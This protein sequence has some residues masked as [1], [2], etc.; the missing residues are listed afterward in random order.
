MHLVTMYVYLLALVCLPPPA[1]T[2]DSASPQFSLGAGS[3]MKA[4]FRT[5]TRKSGSQ[6]DFSVLEMSAR[7]LL[8]VEDPA[9][10]DTARVTLEIK[11]GEAALSPHTR[12]APRLRSVASGGAAPQPA[13]RSLQVDGG[14]GGAVPGPPGPALA[15]R[16]GEA[17]VRGDSLTDRVPGHWP[18]R[19]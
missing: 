2:T 12:P 14:R 3:H 13:R 17:R 10:V 16:R 15:P 11:T 9:Q 1:T 4:G 19:L 18:G 5:V 6:T 8:M 7:P